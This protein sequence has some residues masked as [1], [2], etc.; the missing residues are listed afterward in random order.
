MIIKSPI[1]LEL[2]QSS[3][4]TSQPPWRICGDSYSEV[5]NVN[6]KLTIED[7]TRPLNKPQ[8]LTGPNESNK[9]IDLSF[10][11]NL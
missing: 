8:D 10:I 5:V 11:D 9:I 2:T 4:Q 7:N 3:G 6:D 1:D